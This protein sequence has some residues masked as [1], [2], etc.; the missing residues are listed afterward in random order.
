M[1]SWF[2]EDQ[3]YCYFIVCCTGNKMVNTSPRGKNTIWIKK[4]L[5]G[6]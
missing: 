5:N 4:E 6:V 3:I 2:S 1:Y